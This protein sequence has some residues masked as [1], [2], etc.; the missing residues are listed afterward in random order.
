[1]HNKACHKVGFG[2]CIL[3]NQRARPKTLIDMRDDEF[4]LAYSQALL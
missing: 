3:N 4:G 1:M 2:G